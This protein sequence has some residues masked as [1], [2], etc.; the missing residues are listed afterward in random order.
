[1]DN[2]HLRHERTHSAIGQAVTERLHGTRPA[3]KTAQELAQEERD[4][5]TRVHYAS[6]S[7]NARRRFLDD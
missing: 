6:L 4:R 5:N 1:M 7:R 2:T 3:P